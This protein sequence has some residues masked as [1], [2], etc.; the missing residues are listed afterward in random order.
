MGRKPV[1]VAFDRLRLGPQGRM[2]IPRKLRQELHLSTGQE[3]LARIEDG[4]LILETRKSA[5]GRLRGLLKRGG[6]SVVDE[7]IS[8]RRLAA[9][10]E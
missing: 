4:R 5:A 3:L 7:L 10:N 2:V 6:K 9:K 1:E 8:E